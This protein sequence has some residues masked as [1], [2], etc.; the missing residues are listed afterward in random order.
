[1]VFSET[2][3]ETH[4]QTDVGVLRGTILKT[5]DNTPKILLGA[6]TFRV[7]QGPCCPSPW[8]QTVIRNF[9]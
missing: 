3:N 2:Q 1:M 4:G 7:P 9:W 5:K 6:K 8:L